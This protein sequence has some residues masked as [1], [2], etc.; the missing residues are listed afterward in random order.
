MDVR[1]CSLLVAALA[2]GCLFP[3][4]PGLSSFPARA[5]A[6]WSQDCCGKPVVRRAPVMSP[7]AARCSGSGWVI[8][9]GVLDQRGWVSDP[10]VS[11]DGPPGA[12]PKAACSRLLAR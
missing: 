3:Q 2:L 11:A 7:E 5:G 10:V 1:K 6:V 4:P 9:S 8:V 12:F